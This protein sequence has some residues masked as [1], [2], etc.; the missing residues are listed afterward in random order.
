MAPKISPKPT[1]DKQHNMSNR[2]RTE[3]AYQLAKK[4]RELKIDIERMLSGQVAFPNVWPETQ[5]HLRNFLILL[6]YRENGRTVIDVGAD[7]RVHRMLKEME[8]E[9]YLQARFQSNTGGTLC[10]ITLFPKGMEE[11]QVIN[12]LEHFKEGDD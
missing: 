2:A 3:L 5:A 6:A 1:V 12:T 7:D 9:G 4:A 11:G 8:T 10:Q